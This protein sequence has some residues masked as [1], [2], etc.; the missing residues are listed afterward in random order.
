MTDFSLSN[1]GTLLVFYGTTALSGPRFP[2]YRGI[3][4]TPKY[5]TV[6]RTLRKSD[7]PDVET[8]GF[9]TAISESERPQTHALDRAVTGICTAA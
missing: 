2:R 6:G 4:I 1:G 3:A 5:T 7:Q 8:S 9:E